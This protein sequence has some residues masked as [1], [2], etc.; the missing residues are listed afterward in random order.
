MKMKT[1]MYLPIFVD[2]FHF[3]LPSENNNGHFHSTLAKLVRY[4]SQQIKASQ[5]KYKE[6]WNLRY[7]YNFSTDS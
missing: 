3:W 1:V 7:I 5:K 2:I 6:D 4:L